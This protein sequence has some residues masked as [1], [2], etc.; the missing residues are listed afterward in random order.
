MYKV[1]MLIIDWL[2]SLLCNL[3]NI[4]IGYYGGNFKRNTT[5]VI[6]FDIHDCMYWSLLFY[7]NMHDI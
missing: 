2:I 1:L 3:H 7:V 6:L 4:M 5:L